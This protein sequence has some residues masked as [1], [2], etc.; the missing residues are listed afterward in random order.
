MP[1][2]G[3]TATNSRGSAGTD[4]DPE[5]IGDVI[6]RFR[7]MPSDAPTS[8]A[9]R[10]TLRIAWYTIRDRGRVSRRALASAVYDGTITNV[11]R[12]GEWWRFIRAYAPFLPGVQPTGDG[13]LRFD[14]DDDRP[15]VPADPSHPTD[16]AIDAA[17]TDAINAVGL[18]DPNAAPH[19]ATRQQRAI[20]DAYDHLLEQH[21]AGRRALSGYYTPTTAP[22]DG[23]YDDADRGFRLGVAPVLRRLPGVDAPP[24]VG[25]EWRYVGD[26]ER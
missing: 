10:A 21:R 9:E 1:R 19:L 13:A 8:G 7:A 6:G 20:H 23:L 5:D 14:S 15:A 4:H 12:R 11:H 17:I 16:D 22:V 18:P 25:G 3:P 2:T 24:V 26:R